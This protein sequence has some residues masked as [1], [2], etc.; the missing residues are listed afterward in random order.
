[1]HKQ[2]ELETAIERVKQMEH[3]FDAVQ[4]AMA[5]NPAS[6]HENAEAARMLQALIGYYESRDWL[7]DYERDERGELPHD[8]KRGVLS[9][10]G[11][12]NLLYE[13][14]QYRLCEEENESI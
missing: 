7:E 10:D 12:Y 13:I 9:E 14:E 5:A 3:Y 11:V 4:D 8:L 2:S 1:M 6:L